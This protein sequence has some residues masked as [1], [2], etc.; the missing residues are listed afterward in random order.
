MRAIGM[1][2]RQLLHM[3]M[4][5]AA[6]YAVS[7]LA[8]GG[9]AGLWL[10]RMLYFRLITR[11]FGLIWRFPFGMMTVLAI[12][13]LFSSAASVYAPAARMRSMAITETINEL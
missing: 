12:A 3:I 1:D 10:S 6:T 11:Y 4:A 2:H 5:E 9:V 7:G 13:V 8:V